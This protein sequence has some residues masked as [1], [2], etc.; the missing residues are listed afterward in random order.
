MKSN[1]IKWREGAYTGV[2]ERETGG[3]AGIKYTSLAN[4]ISLVRKKKEL[5][6]QG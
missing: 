2:R 4:W 1:S 3:T 5:N 6:F